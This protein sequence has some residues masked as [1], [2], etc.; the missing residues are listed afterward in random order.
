MIP[1]VIQPRFYPP[2]INI[3]CPHCG[4][5]K[6]ISFRVISA[7][8]DPPSVNPRTCPECGEEV[9]IFAFCNRN[10]NIWETDDE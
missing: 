10:G 1:E 6:S 8:I 9:N 7:F 4:W 3:K 2:A 5:V